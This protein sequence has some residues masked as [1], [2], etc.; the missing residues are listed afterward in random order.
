ME[1]F[2]QVFSIPSLGSRG[3]NIMKWSSEWKYLYR[4]SVSAHC[5]DQ[6]H[7][8]RNLLVYYKYS[9]TSDI[10]LWFIQASHI[11][12]KR[13]NVIEMWTTNV[14][15]CQ[16]FRITVRSFGSMHID[17]RESSIIYKHL[18]YVKH[19]FR[20]LL[21]CRCVEIFLLDVTIAIL[22]RERCFGQNWRPFL[23]SST[24]LIKWPFKTNPILFIFTRDS[25]VKMFSPG[26]FVCVCVCFC[27]CLS[28]C[29]SGRFNHEGLVPHKWYFAGILLGVPSCASYVSRTYDVI[30]DVSRSQNRSNFEIAISPSIFELE[31]RSKAQ[32]VGKAIFL[33]YSTSGITSGKNLSRAQK[34]RPFWIF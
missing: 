3:W 9:S 28:R 20:S 31:R 23:I 11:W 32:N 29:L 33:V 17:V 19:Q 12:I 18:N 27:L 5:E 2:N 21:L 34:K 16:N 26:V 13:R 24:L 7:D 10:E 14:R 8:I 6:L 30:D 25:E 4:F 15:D 22:P 1:N